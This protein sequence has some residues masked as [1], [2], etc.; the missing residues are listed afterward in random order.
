M[1]HKTITAGTDI[2]GEYTTARCT[3]DAPPVCVELT[4]AVPLEH[5]GD[6]DEKVL[7]VW[8]RERWVSELVRAMQGENV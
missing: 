8:A 3:M 4:P 6:A 1:V 2:F 7:H 5:V